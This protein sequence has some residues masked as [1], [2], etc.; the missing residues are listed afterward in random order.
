MSYN[1]EP[2]GTSSDSP[3]I[4]LAMIKLFNCTVVDFNVSAD[5]SSQGGSL[6]CKLIEDEVYNDRLR[7]P[8]LGSP[9]SFELRL[10]NGTRIFQYV[11]IVESFSRN[12]SNSKTYNVSISSPLRILESVNVILDGYTGLGASLEGREDLAGLS[13]N[14]FGNNN[15]LIDV[16]DKRP[17]VYHWWNV[18]NLINV[19]GI[20]ENNDI[21]YRYDAG[22]EGNPSY[23]GFGFSSRSQDGIPLIKLMWA[24][25]AGINH[26]PSLS[27]NARQR[28]LA[29]NILYGRHNYNI[30]L[31]KREA[32]PYYYHFDALHFYYQVVDILGPQFRV[33]GQHK[34]LK[35]II[36]SICD[37]ANLEFY[38]YIDIYN[39][40][41]IGD[42]TL[43]EYD[44]NWTLQAKC[45]WL[46]IP[47]M[48]AR[49]FTLG[50]NYGGTIRVKT[51]NKNA[52]LNVHRPFSNIA[53]N[54]LGLEYPDYR[55]E[56]L[57]VA[58]LGSASY[59]GNSPGN[60][61]QTNITS[62]INQSG[63]PTLEGQSTS[64]HGWEKPN[65]FMRIHPGLKPWYGGVDFRHGLA[66]DDGTTWTDPLDSTGVYEQH[67]TAYIDQENWGW[68]NVGTDSPALGGSFPV[69]RTGQAGRTS[70]FDFDKFYYPRVK[71]SDISIKIND[72]TTM[73]VIIG[74]YQTRMVTVPGTM[75]RQYW[76]DILIPDASDP[77]ETNDTATDPLGLNE[78]SSRKIPVVTPWLDPKD[79]DDFILVDMQSEFAQLT[80]PGVFHGGIY[81][82]SLMEIRCAMRSE[83]S[84]KAFF[85]KYK[86]GKLR[87]LKDYFYP[88]CVNPKYPKPSGTP[89]GGEGEEESKEDLEKS[90]EGINSSGGLG[91]LGCSDYLGLGNS[92]SAFQS[93]VDSMAETLNEAGDP[94]MPP[95]LS[96]AS[97]EPASTE[98]VSPSGSFFGLGLNL[99]CAAAEMNVKKY[100]LPPMAE[101]LKEIGDMHY[102][103][104]WYV[105]V[106]YSTTKE[107]LD[108]ENL[109]GNFKRSWELCD[110]AYIEP[111]EY[112][113][114]QVPQSN[115]FVSDGKVS[116]FVNYNHNFLA[117]GGQ[118]DKSYAQEMTSLI[119]QSKQIFNFSEYSLDSLCTTK[120][121]S[122]SIV[123]AQP[124]NIETQYQF[125]PFAYD[126]LYN[127]AMLPVS[128]IVT[129]Q[130]RRWVNTKTSSG[131][132]P[133]N[134]GQVGTEFA[135]TS[136][137]NNKSS[138]SST[139]DSECAGGAGQ[140]PEASGY[141]ATDVLHN[142]PYIT[143]PNW[144]ASIVPSLLSL[145]YVD[146][147]RFSFPYVKC[148]TSR[149]FEPVPSPK[150]PL[151]RPSLYGFNMFTKDK[152][153]S[154]DC[155]SG[156]PRPATKKQ[157]L[158]TE[159]QQIAILN[160]FQSCVCPQS[161]NYPQVSTRYVYG[162]W[163]T[164]F[165]DIY[166]RGKIE[167]EHDESL[168]PENFLIPTKLS[169][170]QTYK[171]DQTSGL[172]GMNLAAQGR[173]NS[174]DNFALFALEEGSITMPG[175]PAIKRIGDSLYGLQQITDLKINVSNDTIETTYTFKTI[176]PK[177]GKNTRE[178]E[179]KMTK[180]SNDIKKL[181]L[182]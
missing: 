91:Y 180:I 27:Y 136:P 154:G 49:K 78:N 98:D 168:T 122:T 138:I 69:E 117:D 28:T 121:G 151:N 141:Y 181:K 56:F 132:A 66:G 36:S 177:F 134:E 5:W 25:H 128:N 135:K 105:P 133:V 88:N 114:R 95:S 176:A 51:I 4:D 58:R 118:Y 50:G 144:L 129:G 14:D 41:T 159:D 60:V 86:Y 19:F 157:P 11:G 10:Q 42:P 43:L 160:P 20:L 7:I 97:G 76:G 33:E 174:I 59:G 142:I 113:G 182:R 18:C 173:A 162:P 64:S 152:D 112:Y 6:T 149:V 80:I 179:K 94:I 70:M 61:G 109:I 115:S 107:N 93:Q 127:R 71:N 103:K 54:L 169:T 139:G 123:H 104:S 12:A 65:D 13:F 120:Y 146:N 175:A 21:K 68:R 57:E 63:T 74:G 161:I 89:G 140:L 15:V 47:E 178:L 8:V 170:D 158:I 32:I 153:S 67:G 99:T 30:V 24:L 110:S 85:Y 100:I 34:T 29:G 77:R 73:K 23:G 16:M 22:L 9:V 119:G 148:T 130:R 165:S 17:G 72:A 26:A 167:Y 90:T 45:N 52:F 44:P 156:I 172:A 83:S 171:L 145:D 111:S 164:S 81:A 131:I 166:W 48:R 147:G 101:K 35:D 126:R 39:D 108:G 46:D 53:Y 96:S 40:P 2:F 92:F 82:A 116:A 124:E 106:P 37:E 163:M 155:A 3:T 125:L 150:S 38:T 31:D 87:L 102:G 84:W 143:Q 62:F 1:I 55:P 79:V 137:E 75:I